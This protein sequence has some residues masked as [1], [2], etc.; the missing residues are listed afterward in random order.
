MKDNAQ[1]ATTDPQGGAR[2]AAHGLARQMEQQPLELQLVGHSVGSIFHAPL[3]QL[4][5]QRGP[6]GLG[7]SVA[8]CTLWAPGVRLD[9]FKQ[10]YL[11]LLGTDAL[12]RFALYTLDDQ[13]ERS[14]NCNNIYR[15]SILYLV[16]NALEH[17]LRDDEAEDGVPLLGLAKYVQRDPT[18]GEL[19]ALTNRQE[20]WVIA[21]A[22]PR[23]S[24]AKTHGG[25]DNDM[26]TVLSTIELMHTT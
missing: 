21:G 13:D 15:K 6:D 1:K 23:I 5:T 9:V 11:P 12:R 24:N 2:L 19:F 18:L 25:F 16:S 22:D 7:L 20:R 3:L 17:K 10:S 4:L 8:S 26:P 14:D